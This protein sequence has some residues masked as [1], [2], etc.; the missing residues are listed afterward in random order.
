MARLKT[1]CVTYTFEACLPPF[2]GMADLMEHGEYTVN[3]PLCYLGG[4]RIRLLG[5]TCK[6]RLSNP[7]GKW[8]RR[9]LLLRWALKHK[10]TKL[11]TVHLRA[12]MVFADTLHVVDHVRTGDANVASRRQQ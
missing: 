6:R 9:W 2:N 3:H 5:A 1:Y 7:K 4:Q 12:G 11:D 10:V 8:T